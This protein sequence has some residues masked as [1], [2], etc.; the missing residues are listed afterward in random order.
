MDGITNGHEFEQTPED[1]GGERIGKPGVLQS[2]GS[3]GVR[4]N[5]A[6]ERH[7]KIKQ[8][9]NQKQM[10]LAIDGSLKSKR[11]MGVIATAQIP[12]DNLLADSVNLLTLHMSQLSYQN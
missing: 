4:H 3:Q 7:I 5:L 6:T 11:S 8:K 12:L 2:M 1:S 9:E 10:K